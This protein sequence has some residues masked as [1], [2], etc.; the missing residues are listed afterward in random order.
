MPSGRHNV[1]R[2]PSVTPADAG[3]HRQTHVLCALLLA[4]PLVAAKKPPPPPPLTI[5]AAAPVITVSLDGQPLSLR[6]DP[7]ATSQVSLNASAAR[8]LG[9]GN[10]GRLV[11]SEPART[12]T[13]FTDVGKVRLREATTNAILEIDGRPVEVTLASGDGDH[14]DGADGLINPALLP[15]DEVRIVG[16]AATPADSV[17]V[18]PAE[19]DSTRGLISKTL[20]GKRRIDVVITPL[21]RETIATASAAAFI[22]ESQGGHFSGPV[23]DKI[24]SHGVARPVRDIALDRPFDVAGLRLATVAARL[25]DWSGKTSLPAEARP[26]DEV[27]ATARFDGQRQWAKLAIGNDH[28]VRCASIV[29]QRL[30][31][32]ITLTCPKDPR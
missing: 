24:V 26:D 18:L 2:Q 4:V 5:P 13:L 7:A 14:V 20:V 1:L 9:L 10:P 3:A 6:V 27:V 25:F 16:R 8:R 30:P 22:V 32:T 15:H 11:G 28:L 17:T 21:A 19:F 23:G 31:A 29:W 12:G